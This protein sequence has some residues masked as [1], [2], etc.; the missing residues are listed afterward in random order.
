MQLHSLMLDGQQIAYR[1]SLGSGP[2]VLL[3]HGNSS[4]SLAYGPQLDSEIGHIHRMVAVDLPGFGDSQPVYDPDSVLGLQGSARMVVKVAA[5]LGLEDAVLVGWSLGGHIALEALAGLPRCKGV[6][7]FGAP[8]LAFPPDMA[9]AFL[10]NPIMAAGFN[11][12]PTLDEMNAYVQAFFAPGT[13]DIPGLFVEDMRRADG[14]ARAAVGASIRPGGYQDEV[15]LV[16]SMRVPLAVVQGEG[17][18]LVSLDYLRRLPMPSLWR[19]EVQV[20]PGSGHAPQWEQPA[21]FNAL[22]SAFVADCEGQQGDA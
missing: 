21:A 8:P 2:A 19:S 5:A 22:L 15:A 17:E 4:S 13:R 6:L 11:P 16:Q 12:S 3:I 9:A 10:P 14:R 20:I 18:Q 1:Q 7:I